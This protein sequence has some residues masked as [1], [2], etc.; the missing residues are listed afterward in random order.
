MYSGTAGAAV[1]ATGTIVGVG[2]VVVVGGAALVTALE[3]IVVVTGVD[4]GRLAS[5][6]SR[7]A[8]LDDELIFRIAGLSDIYSE[9]E[10]GLG[11]DCCCC[12]CDII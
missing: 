3:V 10:R 5:G 9:G 6:S 11:N 4:E 2:E 8:P 1:G 7:L 12:C